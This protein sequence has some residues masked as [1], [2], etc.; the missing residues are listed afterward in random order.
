MGSIRKEVEFVYTKESTY[1][2]SHPFIELK[3]IEQN[4]YCPSLSLV[5]TSSRLDQSYELIA[6][7][8]IV[9]DVIYPV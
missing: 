4:R 5:R 7:F 6:I 1:K 8:Q 2:R 9:F 3:T